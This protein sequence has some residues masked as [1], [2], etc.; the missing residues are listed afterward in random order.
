MSIKEIFY[1]Q[2]QSHEKRLLYSYRYFDTFSQL[3]VSGKPKSY[4]FIVLRLYL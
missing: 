4:L 3:S 2:E 1:I